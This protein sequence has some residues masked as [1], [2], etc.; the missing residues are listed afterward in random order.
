MNISD[1]IGAADPDPLPPCSTIT[2]TAYLGS[3]VGPYP[4]K[5]P[6]SLLFHGKSLFLIIPVSADS[7]NFN[8]Y[9]NYGVVGLINMPTA[10]IYEESV[11]GLTIYNG[12][13]DKKITLTSNPFDW[14]EASIFYTNIQNRPY[15]EVSYDPVCKQDYKDKGFNI[16]IKVKDE[17]YFPAIALGINDI[18]GT[19]F[20]SSECWS[21]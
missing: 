11:F 5:R 7:F 3:V 16:K 1:A 9:N 21:E 10:R 20:Y 14:M 15:C 12:T 4:I 8:S 2:E 18:A 17:G 19:G 13:P 6:W